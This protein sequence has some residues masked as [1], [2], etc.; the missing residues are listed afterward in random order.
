MNIGLLVLSFEVILQREEIYLL[1]ITVSEITLVQMDLK[2]KKKTLFG[3]VGM[4]YQG[5][6]VQWKPVIGNFHPLIQSSLKNAKLGVCE[7]TR[8]SFQYC[9]YVCIIKQVRVAEL[10]ICFALISSSFT[11]NLAEIQTY[12]NILQQINQ[13]LPLGPNVSLGISEVRSLMLSLWVRLCVCCSPRRRRWCLH[14]CQLGYVSGVDEVTQSNWLPANAFVCF[15]AHMCVC[16]RHMDRT[17]VW[18]R[19]N[20]K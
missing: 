13:T 8:N 11:Q 9:M 3:P 15:T 2:K 19:E 1:F 10:Y 5:I 12:V 4:I 14:V 16:V 18:G 6:P 20:I 17:A 7:Q